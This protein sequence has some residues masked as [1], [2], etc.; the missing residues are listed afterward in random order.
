VE[1]KKLGLAGQNREQIVNAISNLRS[2]YDSFQDSVNQFSKSFNGN[3][4]E[5]TAK[6]ISELLE[7]KK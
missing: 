6:M 3:G 5:N 7:G 1:E 2:D 4:A